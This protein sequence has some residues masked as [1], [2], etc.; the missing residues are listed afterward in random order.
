MV[1]IFFIYY[2][3]SEMKQMQYPDQQINWKMPN[4][5][6]AMLVF[7]AADLFCVNFF[8]RILMEKM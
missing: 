5:L 1:L 6:P 7:K 2:Y 8:C 3:Q 4:S